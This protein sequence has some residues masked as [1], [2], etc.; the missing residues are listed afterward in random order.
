MNQNSALCL[1]V[2]AAST[3]V[4]ELNQF[5]CGNYPDHRWRIEPWG[6]GG[7]GPLHRVVNDNSGLCVAVPAASKAA[8]T[9][10]NQFPCGDHPDHLWRF[11]SQGPDGAGRPLYRIVN[12]NSGLCLSVAGGDTRQTAAVVQ[13]VCGSRPERQWRLVAR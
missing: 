13:S 3:E 11:E 5:G 4:V 7:A 1:A 6:D 8:D 9:I 2:P 10:V 12:H